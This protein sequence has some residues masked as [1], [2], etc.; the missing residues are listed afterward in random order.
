MER[1]L[2]QH[3]WSWE[4]RWKSWGWFTKR[5]ASRRVIEA[6]LASPFLRPVAEEDGT[7]GETR[8]EEAGDGVA[9]HEWVSG[10][11]GVVR[12]KWCGIEFAEVNE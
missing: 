8:C 1:F 2:R 11:W 7:H 9:E 5:R 12:C 10:A 6:R 4:M 3:G